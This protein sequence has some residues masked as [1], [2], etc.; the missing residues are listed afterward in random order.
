MEQRWSNDGALQQLFSFSKRIIWSSFQG[1]HRKSH[2]L[3]KPNSWTHLTT[4]LGLTLTVTQD[5]CHTIRSFESQHETHE[6]L[7]LLSEV[8][9]RRG[10]ATQAGEPNYN[11]QTEKTAKNKSYPTALGMLRCPSGKWNWT[12]K[13]TMHS[14]RR[15]GRLSL[16]GCGC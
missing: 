15:K 4:K 1:D 9:K 2:P 10:R 11:R 6:P 12:W 13:S 5:V 7:T 14:A 16:N 8:D 3:R